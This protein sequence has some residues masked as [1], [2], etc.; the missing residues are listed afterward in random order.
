VSSPTAAATGAQL[1]RAKVLTDLRR[2]DEALAILGPL[3]AA[4]PDNYRIWCAIAHAQLG[5]ND[6]TGAL[7]SA[8]V[9]ASLN[10]E[11]EWPFRLMSVALGRLGRAEESADA[12]GEAVRLAPHSWQGYVRL[13]WALTHDKKKLGQAAAVA[14][15]A[16]ALEPH[17]VDVHVVVGA[18]EMAR[19]HR[20]AAEAAFKRALEIDPQNVAAHNELAR[21]S[22]RR[23]YARP[24]HLAVAAEGFATA[25]RSDPHAQTSR[26]NLDLT[27][28]VFLARTSYLILIDAYV[29]GRAA[30]GAHNVGVRLL[31]AVLLA[32]PAGFA[33]RFLH[34]L[35]ADLRRYVL[36]LLVERK[37]RVPV[38]LDAIAVVL[39]VAAAV[40]PRSAGTVAVGFAAGSAL[41]SRVM[42][43]HQVD[44]SSRAARGLPARHMVS[45]ELLYFIAGAFAIAAVLL[46]A[47]ADGVGTGGS[48]T[49]IGA[50]GWIVGAICA[51]IAVASF[52]Y[53]RRRPSASR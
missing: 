25:V 8:Q 53:T 40:L 7:S 35:S 14:Q 4:E 19:K 22:M 20:R 45:S 30:A 10:P 9:A 44:R 29:V 52:V 11:N 18:V 37:L 49:G 15:T 36:D 43:W 24:G 41:V 23:S 51:A 47:S 16:L 50:P 33:W 42:L 32:I 12:A 13:A 5:L 26:Q 17:E 48:G 6:S 21:L 3:T 34:E 28:R 27:L 31:P 38:A 46:L 39:L 2:Y 1:E